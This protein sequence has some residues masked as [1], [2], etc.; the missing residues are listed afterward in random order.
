MSANRRTNFTR[1]RP[2]GLRPLPGGRWVGSTLYDAPRTVGQR[3]EDDALDHL[4]S[5]GL[6]CCWTKP[7]RHRRYRRAR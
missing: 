5:L 6:C 3:G 7:R 1:S 2:R 4:D